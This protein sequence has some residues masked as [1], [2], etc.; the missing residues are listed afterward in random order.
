MNNPLVSIV[1]ITRRL[2]DYLKQAVSKCLE[3]DYENFEILVLTEEPFAEAFGKTKVLQSRLAPAARRD[4]GARQAG[5]EI[6][7]FLDDDAY[8]SKDWLKNAVPYFENQQTAAVC[9]PGVTPG[10]DS[11]RQKA[12][13]WISAS[14]LGSGVL[15]YR[16]LPKKKRGVKD[17]PSMNFLVRKSDFEKAGGFDSGFWP[18]EDTKLC[19]DLTKKLGKKIIYD[20]KILV[21]HHR[22]PV[23]REHL[24]QNCGYGLHRGYFVKILPQTSRKLFYFLP[25]VFTLFVLAL[26]IFGLF[27]ANLRQ[28]VF[29]VYFQVLNLY[30]WAVI[31][32][33]AWASIK[34]KNLIIGFWVAIGIFLTHVAYGLCFLRGLLMPKLKS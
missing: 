19:L 17:F 10:E 8:P 20:P 34:E 1:I 32:T 7:A 28:P 13:G 12:S 14:W 16:F 9:G 30:F 27:A 4:L 33:G 31:L 23:L 3:L 26:P 21:Y 25:L 29:K 18:G 11:I 6:L 15:G 22:R 24:S 2:N 5:G